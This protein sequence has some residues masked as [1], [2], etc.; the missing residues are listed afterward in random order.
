MEDQLEYLVTKSDF[1]L[2]GLV[3]FLLVF[4]AGFALLG[5][6][7][8]K[9]ITGAANFF[10]DRYILFVYQLNYQERASLE[11]KIP[12][13]QNLKPSL[14]RKFECNVKYF[15]QKKDFEGRDGCTV[16][17]E[18]KLLIAAA[19]TQI[20]F[21]HFPTIYEHFRKIIIYP[22]K[23]FSG[24]TQ[25]YH[26]GEVQSNGVIKLSWAAF[27]EGLRIKN[28][29][30]HVGFHEMAHALKIEDST[31]HDMEHCFMDKK[32]LHD[33]HSY[34]NDRIRS[35]G[36]QSFMR[37]Y[38]FS[39]SEEFFAVSIEYFFETPAQLRKNEPVVYDY[40]TRILKLDP[41]NHTNPVL[42]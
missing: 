16:T 4:W 37:D 25:R 34:S 27:T 9:V 20:S 24:S 3:I 17:P 21:G 42:T 39:N 12:F 26:L 18:M 28:D 11:Y 13:Y 33:F 30:V 36:S 38:A 35:H 7:L 32:A 40:L 23:Y 31:L 15:I 8:F 29:G 14:K 10:F 5:F 1:I 2:P 6:S 19:A 22:D 41:L